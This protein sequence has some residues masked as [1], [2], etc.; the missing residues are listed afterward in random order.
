MKLFNNTSNEALYIITTEPQ[1]EEGT[2]KPGEGVELPQYDNQKAVEVK[3]KN[4]G[5]GPFKLTIPKTR[6]GMA[7]T[8]GIFF[9]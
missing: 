6:P 1:S 9:Q 3:F 2:L 7:V 8:V 5:E 4:A